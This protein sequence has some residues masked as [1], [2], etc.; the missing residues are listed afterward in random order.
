MNQVILQGTLQTIDTD[1]HHAWLVTDDGHVGLI[2]D[3]D[4]S[5]LT[6]GFDEL[7]TG[8]IVLIHGHVTMYRRGTAIEWAHVLILTAEAIR[9]AMRAKAANRWFTRTTAM[10]RHAQRSNVS[11]SGQIEYERKARYNAQ[12]QLATVM[13]EKRTQETAFAEALMDKVMGGSE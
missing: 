2:W 7:K 13:E 4:D 6:S 1:E 12:T 10:M 9:P 11:L 5:N 3:E 8:D